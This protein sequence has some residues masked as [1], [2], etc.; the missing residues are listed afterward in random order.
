MLARGIAK[1]D[2]FAKSGRVECDITNTG[3]LLVKTTLYADTYQSRATRAD[4]T[5]PE[6]WGP[7]REFVKKCPTP[8]FDKADG[9]R[10]ELVLNFLDELQARHEERLATART[11]GDALDIL[12]D[13]LWTLVIESSDH[14]GVRLDQRIQLAPRVELLEISVRMLSQDRRRVAPSGRVVALDALP[15]T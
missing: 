1:F 6:F 5:P 11:L 13:Q 3:K 10:R 4:F 12:A 7:I 2:R 9:N 15:A 8:V 14:S